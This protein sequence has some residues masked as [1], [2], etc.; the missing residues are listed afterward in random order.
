MREEKK[1]EGRA[2]DDNKGGQERERER[3]KR[4]EE[5]GGRDERGR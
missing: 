3:E 1:G 4:S 2:K 5:R